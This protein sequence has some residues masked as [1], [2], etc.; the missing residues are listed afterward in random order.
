[1]TAL[2]PRQFGDRF[3]TAHLATAALNLVGE[4]GDTVIRDAALIKA[5]LTGRDLVMGK[6]KRKDPFTFLP[7][8]AQLWGAN[9]MPPIMDGSGVLRRRLLVLP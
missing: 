3:R 1:V 9:V 2:D 8:C 4:I 5:V 6:N 7:R